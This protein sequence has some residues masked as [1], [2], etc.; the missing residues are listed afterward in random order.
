MGHMGQTFQTSPLKVHNRFTHQNPCIL[1]GIVAIQAVQRIVKFQ[2]WIFAFFSL[3]WKHMT[4]NVSND[5]SESG[6][7]IHSLKGMY[8]PSLGRVSTKGR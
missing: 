8:T 6:H 1:L 2:F 4:V 5:I 3:T 7:Q